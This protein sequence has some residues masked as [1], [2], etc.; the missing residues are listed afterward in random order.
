MKRQKNCEW[1]LVKQHNAQIKS[2]FLLLLLSIPTFSEYHS[3]HHDFDRNW[4]HL[5][6]TISIL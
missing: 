6:F 2:V 1:K 5:C 3:E 4:I